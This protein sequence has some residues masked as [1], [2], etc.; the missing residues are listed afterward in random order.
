MRLLPTVAG[1]Y[2]NTSLSADGV[3]GLLFA[4][5][6]AVG[7]SPV[8]SR[9]DIQVVD[10]A[11]EVQVRSKLYF[12]WKGSDVSLWVMSPGSSSCYRY[13][14]GE[15]LMAN[16]QVCSGHHFSHGKKKKKIRETEMVKSYLTR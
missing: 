9:K 2:R 11:N 10:V 4:G 8:V 15:W 13:S 7:Y 14:G 12:E 6:W 5:E 3:S 16:A 1:M